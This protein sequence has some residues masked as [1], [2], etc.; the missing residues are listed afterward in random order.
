MPLGDDKH[1]LIYDEL[2]NIIGTDYVSDDPAVVEAYSRE[3]QTPSF[4]TR[5]RTEFVVLPNS[6]EDVRQIIGLANR[7]E[8]PF[9]VLGTGLYF[10]TTSA[11]KPYWC[12]IDTKRM[13]KIEIDNKNMYAIVEPYVSLAQV[14]AEAM[15]GGLYIG[16]PCAAEWSC[17]ANHTMFGLHGTA[18]RTGYASRNVLGVEWVLPGGE[19]LRTGSLAIPEE[20]Y[21]WGEGP[22]PDARG[23]L[24]G[25][26]GHFGA[27]GV[28][29][30]MAVKLYTWP[31]PSVFPT[32]GVAPDKK[33]ELPPERFRWYLFTYPTL[34]Q[35]IEAIRE[36]SK[37]EI[38]LVLQTMCPFIHDVLWAKSREEYWTSWVEE[39]WQSN[40]NNCVQV[41]LWGCASEKQ[42]EYEEK[43][44][45]EIIQETGGTLVPDEVFQR[46]APYTANNSIRGALGARLMRMSGYFLTGL[47]FDSLDDALRSFPVSWEILDTHT[48]PFLDSAHP[49]WSVSYD[50]GHFATAEAD[51]PREKTDDGDLVLGKAL[52][53]AIMRGAKDQTIGFVSGFWRT[54]QV[55]P[56]FANFHLIVSKI[57]KAI[58]PHNVANPTR[59]IDM[60]KVEKAGK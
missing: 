48:P 60:E 56:S 45:R 31:G 21:W 34:E 5:K 3:S 58:D 11:V 29:T 17:L 19:I 37:A 46:W 32:E 41:C 35:T 36:I 53:E 24:R 28:I 59:F 33:S 49:A 38:G 12:M 50:M 52:E 44:L 40:L 22:G 6:T 39:Y 16:A 47:T 57:K 1:K 20:G 43:V 54:H 15:K 30:K 27:F 55:G 7:Y 2:V 8:F 42:V 14:Q 13:N 4:L 9:S 23:L 10:T 51:L 25:V 26:L 18:Y